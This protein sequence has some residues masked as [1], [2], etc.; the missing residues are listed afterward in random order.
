M[1]LH[2]KPYFANSFQKNV[3]TLFSGTFIAQIINVLGALLLAKMYAPEL[4]G[5][6]NVFLSFASILLILNTLKLE[7]IIVTED[8]GERSKNLVFILSFLLVIISLSH[9][10]FFILSSDFF[11]K[12]NIKLVVLLCSSLASLFLAST[13]IF[14]SYAT[15]ISS[16]KNIAQV[17]I[18]LSL[19][20]IGLQFLFF[21]VYQNGLILGYIIALVVACLYY[22]Y[23]LKPA[24]FL[25]NWNFFRNSIEKNKNI[26]KFAFPSGLINSIGFNIMPILLVSYFSASTTG[27]YSLSLKIVSVPLFLIASSVSQ[28]FFQKASVFY[29]ETKYKLY[30][31]TKKVAISSIIT[32]FVVLLLINTI[33]LFMLGL[34]FDKH[35]ENLNLLVIILSFYM[36]CQSAFVPV[37]HIIVIVNKMHVGLI[38]NICL[39]FI[40]LIAIY[41]GTLYNN[42]LYTVL[43]LSV[44]GGIGYLALLLYF[45]SYLRTFKNED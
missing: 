38:F 4:Y 30:G 10:L 25:L 45:L 29:N 17:R 21:F 22:I 11:L 9:F 20:T 27:V 14:E 42:I 15:R 19:S 6:Y 35:W 1:N 24:P 2:F 7:Y 18:L 23:V 43:I 8:S 37:S 28:V 33:G 44:V 12:H 34:V 16:F 40:N 39:V 13:K 3:A 36:L 5:T 26:L 41:V 32:M 31:L